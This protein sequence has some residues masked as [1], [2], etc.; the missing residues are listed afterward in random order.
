MANKR[1]T[2]KEKENLS[3]ELSNMKDKKFVRRLKRYMPSISD[4]FSTPRERVKTVVP[5]LDELMDDLY[6][7]ATDNKASRKE[8]MEAAQFLIEEAVPKT[9]FEPSG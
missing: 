8:R 2:R 4:Y 6:R 7:L 5:G 1:K 9:S 3:D